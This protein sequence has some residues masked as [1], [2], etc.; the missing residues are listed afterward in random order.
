MSLFFFRSLYFLIL[1]TPLVSSIDCN[2]KRRPEEKTLRLGVQGATK[3]RPRGVQRQCLGGRPGGK[4]PRSSWIL[5]FLSI[6]EGIS[7]VSFLSIAE[8][9]SKVSFFRKIYNKWKKVN[10]STKIY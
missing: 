4:T 5:A 10:F 1:F 8:G 2:W 6:A 7:K 9:I 3:D